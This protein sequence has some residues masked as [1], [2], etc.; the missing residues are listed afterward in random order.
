MT[1]L[2]GATRQYFVAAE[3]INWN[4]APGGNMLGQIF[5]AT[6]DNVW[7]KRGAQGLPPIFKKAVFREYTD[8]TFATKTVLS[9]SWAHL[10]I[11]GP[12][13]RAEVGDTI[14]VTL[15]NRTRFPVS[16]H[17]HGVQ[18]DKVNE[19]S[20]YIAGTVGKQSGSFVAPGQTFTYRWFVPE[21]AGPGPNEPSSKAW[22]YHSHV[23]SP[24]D[25][26]AG[27]IGVIIVTRRGEARPD[28]SP[29]GVDRE[30]VTLYTILDENQSQLMEDNASVLVKE[31]EANNFYTI[32]GFIFGNVPHLQMRIGE[33]VRWYLIGFGSESDIHVPH[34]HGNV[35]MVDGK[36]SDV[37][38]LLPA[39]MRVADMIPDS[40][41]VWFYHCHVDEHMTS[42][43]VARYEVMGPGN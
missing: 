30:F 1:S 15:K 36:Q 12:V 32:N 33:K 5:C 17:P 24:R 10:G 37:V 14:A 3:E 26:N 21:R 19:G 41:G 27:L 9:E 39:S 43:M 11:L 42:G 35:V 16:I 20:D 22:L 29:V 23:D 8:Q 18:Y 7:V 4:Y 34:W 38:E 25:T 6:A 40:I 13:F 31:P 28:G 2:Y